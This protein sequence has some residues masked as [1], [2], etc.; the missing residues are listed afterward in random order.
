MLL[1]FILKTIFR[2]RGLAKYSK[3]LKHE[4]VL[5]L[6]TST[7]PS[8]HQ[9]INTATEQYSISAIKNQ[10]KPNQNRT[11]QKSDLQTQSQA[12]KA[13][14]LMYYLNVHNANNLFKS[15]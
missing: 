12:K 4:R 7:P 8:T 9:P 13:Q 15:D 3:A 14:V 11:E 1:E 5:G 6:I 10:T 2:A